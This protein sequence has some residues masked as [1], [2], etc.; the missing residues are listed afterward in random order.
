MEA[1]QLGK[2]G[3]KQRLLNR[4]AELLVEEQ[5]DQGTFQGVPHYSGLEQAARRLG[6]ELSRTS[7]QRL[8]AEVAATGETTFACPRCGQRHPGT[9]K[10]RTVTSLDG[11]VEISEPT[12]FW[13]ACRRDFFPSA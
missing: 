8:S 12:A 7:Q 11:E 9:V 13:P 2:S 5:R 1:E 4:L 3:E 6:Q 10:K